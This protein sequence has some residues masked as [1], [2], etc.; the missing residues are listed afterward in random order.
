[1]GASMQIWWYVY[2]IYKCV[3]LWFFFTWS[4]Y[5]GEYMFA[6][7]GSWNHQGVH[8]KQYQKFYWVC[9][10]LRHNS[11]IHKLTLD[12]SYLPIRDHDHG[13]IQEI[14]KVYMDN[15]NLTCL[16]IQNA[17]VYSTDYCNVIIEALPNLNLEAIAMYPDYIVDQQYRI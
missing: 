16:T 10:G 3:R 13:T 8:L 6:I 17:D 15:N 4:I 9:N 11:S 12:C 14:L 7:S 5:W 2:T 1:M